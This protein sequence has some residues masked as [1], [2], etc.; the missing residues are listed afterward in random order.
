MAEKVKF[1]IDVETKRAVASIKRLDKAVEDL[2]GKAMLELIK[3]EQK[4]IRTKK[5]L[6]KVTG[7]A[8]PVFSKFTKGIALGNLAATAMT[9]AIGSLTKGLGEIGKAVLIA[10]RISALNRVYQFTGKA[11]GI[12]SIQL[13][14]YK[15]SLIASGIAEKEALE[16]G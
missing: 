11:A 1:D 12:S 13:N 16:Y 3:K 9:K 10:A 2:G 6:T 15:N 4:L 7:K 8:T 5:Q 14:R